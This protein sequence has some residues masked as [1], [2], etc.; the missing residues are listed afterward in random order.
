MSDP[1]IKKPVYCPNCGGFLFNIVVTMDAPPVG[2]IAG[3]EGFSCP[4]RRC[5]YKTNVLI[6]VADGG[7]ANTVEGELI[8]QIKCQKE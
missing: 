1:Q 7:D 5:G 8:K 3:I 6:G 4:N 2:S